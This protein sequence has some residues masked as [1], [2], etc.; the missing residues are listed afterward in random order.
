[1]LLVAELV[2]DTHLRAQSEQEI[3][4]YREVARAVG[5]EHTAL[6]ELPQVQALSKEHLQD[7]VLALAAR[8]E[9][10]AAKGEQATVLELSGEAHVALAT[11]SEVELPQLRKKVGVALRKTARLRQAR[12][13][14]QVALAA[15]PTEDRLRE[16]AQSRADARDAVS[17]LEAEQRKR[18]SDVATLDREL[19][20]LRE[21]EAK[22]AEAEA[23]GRFE[24]EDAERLLRHSARV[25]DTLQR[26]RAA[27]VA[28]QVARIE[29]L[30]LESFHLLI[31][32]PDLVTGL[33]IDPMTFKL[34]LSGRDG[35]RLAP[36]RLS[37]GERQL[38]AVAILWGLAK[39]SGRPLP[40]VIDT[41]L[42][43][44]DSHHRARLV[45]RYFP[46]ASHQVVLLSTDE[47]IAGEYYEALEP[48]I[49]RTYH[50]AFDQAQGRTIVQE[51]YLQPKALQDVA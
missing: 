42:G 31:R 30:V 48:A 14:A 12:D 29:R 8:R 43:R 21:R 4:R 1:L 13:E 25:R 47:E 32:K 41:P 2:K 39:A 44:L 28:R 10:H 7:L 22:L 16:L 51:G 3:I 33:K 36:E 5:D 24:G 26:F 15:A 45:A 18:E 11:V 34:E 37:A 49:G 46:C 19:A 35:G 6:L 17:K 20:V 50:L 9:R 23:R 40:T 27:V 38:L